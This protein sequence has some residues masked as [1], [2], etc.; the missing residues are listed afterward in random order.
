MSGTG[1]DIENRKTR[2]QLR[3]F[4][5]STKKIV[6]FGLLTTEF[7]CLI[8]THPKITTYWD[9]F[10]VYLISVH[11]RNCPVRSL[12]LLLAMDLV[13][14]SAGLYEYVFRVFL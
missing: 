11:V 1:G 5:R 4:P 10:L 13:S 3:P 9:V 12:K 8:S 6:N 14:F 2:D 7:S